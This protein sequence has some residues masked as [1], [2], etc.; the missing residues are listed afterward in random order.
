M[1]EVSSCSP[2]PLASQKMVPVIGSGMGL[3]IGAMVGTVM[4]V[5]TGAGVGE[6]ADTAMII[7]K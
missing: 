4:V 6:Q 7:N 5:D 3:T 2:G 1:K